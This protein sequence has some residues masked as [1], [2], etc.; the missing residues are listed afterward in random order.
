MRLCFLSFLVIL[1]FTGIQYDAAG[2][3]KASIKGGQL[4]TTNPVSFKTGTAVLTS[5][6]KEAVLEMKEFLASREDITMVRIEGHVAG[7]DHDQQLSGDRAKVVWAQLVSSGIDCKRLIA[8]SF[9]NTKPVS[10]IPAENTRITVAIA[11]L[12]GRM[13]GGMPADGGGLVIATDCK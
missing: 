1:L 5:E 3:T 7:T 2:Q 10:E 6:G 12:R 4:V 9:G 8:A 13:I 11:G